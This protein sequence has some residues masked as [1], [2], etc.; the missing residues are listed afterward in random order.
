M[1]VKRRRIRQRP[2]ATSPRGAARLRAGESGAAVR[3]RLSDALR[4]LYDPDRIKA[5]ATELLGRHLGV[6]RVTYVEVEDDGRTLRVPVGYA[7]EGVP[8]V[9]GEFSLDMFGPEVA[10]AVRA[11]RTLAVDDVA[12]LVGR[13]S[14]RAPYDEVE[15]GAF[16]AVPLVKDGGLAGLLAIA[17][18]EPRPFTSAEVALCEEVAER[19]WAAVERARADVALRASEEKY[20]S[21]FDSMEQ[22]FCIIDVVFEGE[23]AVDYRFVEVNPAFERQTG[24]VEATGRSMRALAPDHEEHWFE[25]YGRVATTGESVRFQQAAE[26]LGFHY[27]VFAFRIGD[28]A[29]R[30]VAVL[31]DD[32]TAEH[33]AET[34]QREADARK[35]TFIAMLGHELRNPLAAIRNAM[36]VM[37][38]VEVDDARV[39]A[40]QAVLERQV[41]HM[42]RLVE[43]LLDVS[44]ITAG[45]IRLETEV[46]DLR[47]IVETVIGDRAH[48]FEAGRLEHRVV[49]PAAP[50]WVEVD[51]VRL[52]QAIDNLV[53]NAIKFTDVAGAIA[54]EV[55]VD[56]GRVRVSV[57]DTGVG[58]M[59]DLLETLFEP[60]Q[61][62]GQDISRT[63]GGLGLGLALARGLVEL[64]GGSLEAHSA[65]W[66]QGSTFVVRLPLTDAPGAVEAEAP[67]EV[68][69]ARRVLVVEDNVDAAEML[70]LLLSLAGHAVRT[71]S[72]GEG[73][74]AALRDEPFDVVLCDLGLPDISGYA[75]ARAVR[76]DAALA[77]VKLVAL[78]GYGQPED[79]VQSA[80]AGFD[81]HL[82]KPAEIEAI[83]AAISA[84]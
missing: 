22:G 17:N 62:G 68:G 70:S 11:G 33:A 69:A 79:R 66:G 59:P 65:G 48:A 20:R 12:A 2:W 1:R 7:A 83:E 35:N 72:T 67:R 64:H 37:R 5:A 46:I 4:P 42:A 49:L 19:T 41:V 8:V 58:I 16:V 31:F 52:T 27:D 82:V 75:V 25:I 56:A 53:G 47:G 54:V 6:S 44:R 9:T 3:M 24:L 77:A 14:G 81:E 45:K 63:S 74:L 71:V 78:S 73:A 76:A 32:I 51:R 34:A 40:V 61:Q 23:R 29:Q 18:T 28:P 13:G 55:S 26:A 21:L 80:E 84:S 39:Q 50:V 15:A 43:G 10:G 60:F 57:S 36:Q 30:R 38:E